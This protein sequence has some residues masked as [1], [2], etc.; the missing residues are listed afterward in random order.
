MGSTIGP[1]VWDVTSVVQALVDDSA[2]DHGFVLNPDV[3]AL[4]DAD[5]IFASNEA[6]DANMRP[7]LTITYNAP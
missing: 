1:V 4:Q 2:A 7:S 5:R 6:V 3:G